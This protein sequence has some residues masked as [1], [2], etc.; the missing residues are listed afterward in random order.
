MNLITTALDG[1][2]VLQRVELSEKS[3]KDILVGSF[4]NGKKMSKFL[5]LTP[6]ETEKILLEIYYN[7]DVFVQEYL[8]KVFGILSKG[9]TGIEVLNLVSDEALNSISGHY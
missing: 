1:S 8:Q 7:T 3:Y 5:D 9:L 6:K 2:D 4:D